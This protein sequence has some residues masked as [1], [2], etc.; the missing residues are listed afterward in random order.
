MTDRVYEVGYCKPPIDTRFKKG[1]SGCPSGGRKNA[2]SVSERLD[3]ILAEKMSVSEGGKT[4][5]MPKE[6]IFLRQLVS[7]AI[8][9]ERQASRVLFDYLGKRQQQPHDKAN[10][11]TDDFLMDELLAMFG[12][13]AGGEDRG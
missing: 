10:T 6:E 13:T 9:G 2:K 1:Q 5:R 3:A 12:D 8:S 11:S 4:L 7:R